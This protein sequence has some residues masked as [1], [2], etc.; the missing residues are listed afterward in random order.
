MKIGILTFHRSVNNGAVLQAYSLSKKIK[1]EY[2]ESHV[3]IIDYNMKKIQDNYSFTLKSY[4]KCRSCKEF[5]SKTLRLIKTPTYL[6][7]MKKRTSVFKNCLNK[8]PLSLVTIIDD[9]FDRVFDY[10]NK[11]CDILIVGSDA[12]WNFVS[13]GFPNAY[14]PDKSVTCIKVGYAASCYGMDYLSCNIEQR[15]KICEVFDDFSL[16]GV[17]DDATENFVRWS[18]C[19]VEPIHTCDP[20]VFLD[21]NDLPIE[22]KKLIEKLSK[23]GFDFKRP[24]IAMMGSNNMYRMLR[25][26]YGKSY[27]IVALYEYIKGADVNLYDLEPYEWAYVFRFFKITFTTYFHGTLLSLKN[28]VPVICISLPTEFSKKHMPKTLD[29]LTRLGF[30]DW[31]FETDYKKQ[32]FIQIKEKANKLISSEIKSEIFLRLEKEA[33]SFDLFNKKLKDIIERKIYD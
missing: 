32:N 23:K 17:R 25:K 22:E 8:L 5:I 7:K 9:K 1:F 31:Y 27:Q 14:F 24:A 20:T 2:P 13:R 29:L 26:F 21:L 28:G 19:K 33:K 12:V 6:R 10:I 11:N 15:K 16:I 18:N 30:E 3:E 4:Y